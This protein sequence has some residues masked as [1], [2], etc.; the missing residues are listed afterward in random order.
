M[1]RLLITVIIVFG[2][3]FMTMATSF[4][5][6]TPTHKLI[7]TYVAKTPLNGF[8]LGSYLI[9]QLGF[10][11]GITSFFNNKTVQDWLG[12][13]GVYEDEPPLF[14]LSQYAF[15]Y[16]GRSKNHFHNP[17][18][19]QGYT[20]AWRSLWGVFGLE[21]GQSSIQWS[22][23]DAQSPGGHYSW[24]DARDYF[25]TA[26]T[27]TTDTDRQQNYANMFRGLGQLMHLVEDLSVPDHTRN[28]FHSFGGYEGWVSGKDGITTFD[29]LSQ[30]P[31]IFFDPLSIGNK[32]PLAAVPIANLFDNNKYHG[33]NPNASLQSNVG[34]SEYTNANFLSSGTM[35]A[36]G[37]TYPNWNSVVQN[38][39]P[40]PVTK[41]R[42]LTK[43][44]KNET[45]L[46]GKIGNG[47]HINHLAVDRWGS[48]LLPSSIK[49]TGIN[50]KMDKI[51]YA[52]YAEKLIPRAVGYAAQ[53]L[54]YFF[55]GRIDVA[56]SQ[57]TAT[58][59]TFRV[60]NNTPNEA[61]G[62]GTL[63]VAYE[64]NGNYGVSSEVQMN[65][66]VA[67]GS[68]STNDYTVTFSQAI[69]SD[70]DAKYR[71]VF[72]GKLGNENNAVV[73][74]LAWSSATGVFGC[75]P[76]SVNGGFVVPPLDSGGGSFSVNGKGFWA[77]WGIFDY[78]VDC[79]YTSGYMSC[80]VS[81]FYT[82][83]GIPVLCGKNLCEG[84]W[85]GYNFYDEC[86]LEQQGQGICYQV[87]I[88]IYMKIQTGIDPSGSAANASAASTAPSSSTINNNSGCYVLKRN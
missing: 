77:E 74:K 48:N 32:N 11:G 19:K 71:L 36:P 83:N 85:N 68:Q 45:S 17:L 81:S 12:A 53:L 62:P 8:S 86:I 13:G 73:A 69:P 34:L 60:V 64:Y 57:M 70:A 30:H 75:M 5:L 49:D 38:P 51:V 65:E 87:C 47:E 56:N 58:S 79:S 46:E 39:D 22:Q 15:P 55:R 18:N 26:L 35:F 44:G 78:T 59:A 23:N 33:D 61:M 2:A 20:G 10:Q 88:P 40:D 31:P 50:L 84:S 41:R 52:D 42:Y 67:A 72:K 1:K 16:I 21:N 54:N 6:N 66:T 37:F 27:S 76:D 28:T 63:V 80:H 24:L 82:D 14:P 4:A 25:Y 3:V 7:N 29:K 43:L 9:G